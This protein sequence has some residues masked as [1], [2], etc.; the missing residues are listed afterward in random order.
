MSSQSSPNLGCIMLNTPFPPWPQFTPEE[1]K[2]VSDVMQSNRVNYWTG[3]ECR[4][5]ER[6]F[7]AWCGTG[8]A[9]SV[10]NGTLALDLCWQA[11][12]LQ[13][14]DEVI[15]T[16]R[17]FMASASSIVTAGARPVFA[18]VD[19]NSQNITPE[20]VIPHLTKKTRAILCV[21][22]AG[23][24]CD[25]ISFRALARAH[26]LHLVEDCAQAH[27][28]RIGGQNVGSWSTLAA[29]SFCQDKIMTTGGEGGMVTM[30]DADLW[31]DIWSRKDHGK[32]WSS[33]YEKQHAP[34]FRW[35]HDSFGSNYRMIEVQ[36][37][38]G[39][40]QLAMLPEWHTRRLENAKQIWQTSQKQSVLRVPSVPENITHAAYKAYVFVEPKA[41]SASW[42]RDRIC[43]E[44]ESRGV[45]CYHG[46]C[47]EIYLEM[48][49]D[50]HPS[51]PQSRLPNAKELGETSLMFLVHPNLE[52]SHIQK[53]TE[54]ISDVCG[55]AKR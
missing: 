53:T 12:N 6:E 3:Q 55:L 45:P 9:V 52:E 11:L 1:I 42:S 29:W 21:H 16:P 27:G 22:L 17:S 23:W 5:F 26:N 4:T 25:M 49:F 41:L 48:A 28:A 30:S 15:C 34:G 2:A 13:P 7:A 18:D 36:A 44:I 24:P 19:V 43:A 39:R 54:V 37:A 32:S 31:S 20:T 14:G 35:V 8:H 38:I 51:R 46:S 10:S 50:A 47:P 40:L 33:V